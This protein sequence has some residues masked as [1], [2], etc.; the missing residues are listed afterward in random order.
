[1]AATD[2][3]ESGA[4][5]PQRR[6]PGQTAAGAMGRMIVLGGLDLRPELLV[7]R[8]A[9]API[10]EGQGV[11]AAVALPL[12]SRRDEFLVPLDQPEAKRK[13]LV[14]PGALAI[15]PGL[16]APDAVRVGEPDLLQLL[17]LLALEAIEAVPVSPPGL[18]VEVGD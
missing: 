14:G 18:V 15:A 6:L 3:G 16:E 13:V 9:F 1:G 17:G 11:E 2:G 4:G 7:D 10:A 12:D 8:L 5:L